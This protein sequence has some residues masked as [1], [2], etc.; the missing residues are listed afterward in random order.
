MKLTT[1]FLVLGGLCAAALPTYAALQSSA[2]DGVQLQLAVP[3]VQQGRLVR[4]AP[5]EP[6]TQEQLADLLGLTPVHINRT[7]RQLEKEGAIRRVSRRGRRTIALPS[8]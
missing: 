3:F 7:L 1:Q 8:S 2:V 4:A 6:L 5:V